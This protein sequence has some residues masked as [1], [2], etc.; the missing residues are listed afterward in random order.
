MPL[1]FIFPHHMTQHV[2]TC[3]VKSLNHTWR[4]WLS[5]GIKPRTPPQSREHFTSQLIGKI[6]TMVTDIH[7]GSLT[8]TNKSISAS[9]TALAVSDFSM[10]T[11]GHRVQFSTTHRE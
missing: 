2:F 3:L 9:H 11:A 8:F 6:G 4:C 7:L 10:Y 1:T 5:G